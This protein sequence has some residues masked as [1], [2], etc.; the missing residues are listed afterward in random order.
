MKIYLAA[1]YSRHPEMRSHAADLTRLGHEVTS[2]WILGDHELLS[3]GQSDAD[4]WA[5]RWATEDW[6]DLQA[7]ALVISFTEA[8]GPI[9][10][11]GRGGRHVE[12]GAALALGKQC[13]VVGARENV[14][15][16]LPHVTFHATWSACLAWL[17]TATK[18]RQRP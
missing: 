18:E 17:E 5:I 1:R 13:V 3:R 12:F 16:H 2:R 8:P 7:A 11:R 9:P 4:P 14:F 6:E 10:G 15:H